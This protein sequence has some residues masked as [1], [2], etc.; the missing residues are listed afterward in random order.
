MEPTRQA[1]GPEWVNQTDR[2]ANPTAQDPEEDQDPYAQLINKQY[3]CTGVIGWKNAS[4]DQE[5]TSTTFKQKGGEATLEA[6]CSTKMFSPP[7]TWGQKFKV[8]LEVKDQDGNTIMVSAA[9]YTVPS[10]TTKT[11]ADQ[12]ENRVGYTGDKMTVHYK[13][14]MKEDVGGAYPNKPFTEWKMVFNKE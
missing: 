7:D 10:G 11:I 1:V 4:D 9:E 3:K 13:V 6:K 5:I 8:M 2:S 14:F 12:L